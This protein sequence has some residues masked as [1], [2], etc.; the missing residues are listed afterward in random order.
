VKRSLLQIVVLVLLV[1]FL[2]QGSLVDACTTF[3]INDGESLVFGRNYDWSIGVGL[4]MVNRSGIV[5]SALIPPTDVPAQWVSKYGNITF[6]QYGRGLPMGGM[7]EKG[8]VVE[9]MWLQETKYP[10]PDDRGALRELTWIQYQLDNCETVDEVIATDSEVR[11]TQESVP[12]HFLICDARGE[13][14]VIEFL[15]GKMVAH[16]G[17]DLSF[18]ALANSTYENSVRYL[19]SCKGFGGEKV[20]AD[21]SVSSLDRFAKAARG[22]VRYDAAEQGGAVARAFGILEEVSQGRAT[23]WSIVYDVKN[24]AILF[25]TGKSP[26]IKILNLDEFDFGCQAPCRVLDIDC[27]ATGVVHDRFVDY[28]VELNETL[29]YDAWKN[30]SFLKN[31]PDVVLD[32]I[33]C[34]PESYR[35]A[36]KK[37]EEKGE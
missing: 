28:S 36:K 21:D 20:I 14:A 31:T 22:V 9:Q 12:I 7:N 24:R 6:N 26:K 34:H 4:V 19:K 23:R 33:A 16:R 10:E 5:K 8:L 35:P 37:G 15:E 25:R 18:T 3:C 27:D 29:I 13:T 17:E 1:L 32:V 11:I 2:P 30:T